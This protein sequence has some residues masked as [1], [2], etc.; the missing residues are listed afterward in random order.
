MDY[1][2]LTSLVEMSKG[3]TTPEKFELETLN[4]SFGPKSV[5]TELSGVNKYDVQIL[6]TIDEILRLQEFKPV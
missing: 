6:E 1:L 5:F 4:A 2:Q 3:K